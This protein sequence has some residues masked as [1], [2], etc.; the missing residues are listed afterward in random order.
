MRKVLEKDFFKKCGDLTNSALGFKSEVLSLEVWESYLW[1]LKNITLPLLW[2]WL[3]RLMRSV[4][5]QI[6]L[7][8]KSPSEP[9]RLPSVWIYFIIF[10]TKL[11][12]HLLND[13]FDPNTHFFH[14]FGGKYH[15]KST[16]HALAASNCRCIFHPT[17]SCLQYFCW[18]APMI[19]AHVSSLI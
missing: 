13:I 1:W 10:C 17:P 12:R 2:I 11:L 19:I 4:M 7:S 18:R 9:S 6:T 3:R 8:I 14:A 15:I 16:L 5:Q